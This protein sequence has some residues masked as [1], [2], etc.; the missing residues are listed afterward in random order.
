M[1]ICINCNSLLEKNINVCPTCGTL[2][3]SKSIPVQKTNFT[4]LNVLCVLTIIGSFFTIG[5][6][7]LYEAIA[8]AAD[9]EEYIRGWIYGLSSVITIIG[10]V[11]MKRKEKSGL[12]TYTIGQS[13]Y[14]L[15]VIWATSIYSSAGDGFAEITLV[16]SMIFLIPSL[17][18]L[19]IYWSQ[20]IRSQLK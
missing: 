11:L 19:G 20:S 15:T 2:R 7:L 3:E 13:I 16:I 8:H 14:I 6:A 12:L 17:F 1:S 9:N 18:F 10:A 5:R 4:L